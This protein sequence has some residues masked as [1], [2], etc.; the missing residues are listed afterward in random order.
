[1]ISAMHTY[2]EIFLRLL[3]KLE[4]VVL[5]HSDDDVTGSGRELELRQEV[6]GAVPQRH[7]PETQTHAAS[8]RE[9]HSTA[10]FTVRL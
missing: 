6:T 1:M 5:R 8:P 3:A 9:I 10:R 2:L 4:R 7:F